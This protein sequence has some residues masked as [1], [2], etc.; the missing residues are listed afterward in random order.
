MPSRTLR[1]EFSPADG[2]ET[3]LLRLI[4]SYRQQGFPGAFRVVPAGSGLVIAPE[5]ESPLA[6]R[7]RI[8]PGE[9][10]FAETVKILTDQLQPRILD[11][12]SLLPGGWTKDRVV[13]G[14]DGEPARAVLNRLAAAAPGRTLLWRLQYHPR[15]GY[16]LRWSMVR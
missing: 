12:L 8:P 6:A 16:A 1:F 14:A 3:V 7:V 9:R 11:G 13:F 5:S 2:A 4:A 15:S 10:S